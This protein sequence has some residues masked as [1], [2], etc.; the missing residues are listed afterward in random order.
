MLAY[1]LERV[2]WDKHIDGWKSWNVSMCVDP[3]VFTLLLFI[4]Y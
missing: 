3:P 1:G 2:R 4:Q